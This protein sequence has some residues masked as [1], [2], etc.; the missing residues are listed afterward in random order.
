V[1]PITER[2]V[3]ALDSLES[4]ERFLALVFDLRQGDPGPGD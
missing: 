3:E 4:V 2:L 1:S